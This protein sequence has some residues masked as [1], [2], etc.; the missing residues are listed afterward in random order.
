MPVATRQ[1]PMPGHQRGPPYVFLKTVQYVLLFLLLHV[2]SSTW[3]AHRRLESMHAC[4]HLM[5]YLGSG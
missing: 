2:H 4:M 1:K 3:K 5:Q